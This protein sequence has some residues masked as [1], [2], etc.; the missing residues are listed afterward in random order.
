VALEIVQMGGGR[1]GWYWWTP[2]EAFPEYAPYVNVPHDILDQFQTLNLGDRLSDGG[3][4]VTEERGNWIVK[5]IEPERHLVLYAG[6]RMTAGADYDPEQQAPQGI[7]FASSWAFVLR[8]TGP[9]QTRLLVRVRA[10]GEPAWMFLAL[11]FTLRKG[12]TSA[13]S[14]M[15]ERIKVRAEARYTPPSTHSSG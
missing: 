7:W 12:D 9:G 2:G 5:A 1:G 6:R 11:G 8:P 3:P 13:H 14:S 15:L 4:Y 10:R